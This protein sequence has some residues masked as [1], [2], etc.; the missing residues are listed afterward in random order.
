MTEAKLNS[1]DMSDNYFDW[2]SDT[3]HVKD[4][5]T[6]PGRGA[7]ILTR[8]DLLSTESIS[9]VRKVNETISSIAQI[10][11]SRIIETLL[12]ATKLT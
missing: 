6:S 11:D 10:G 2:D 7:A 4:R 5:E 9:D 3:V 12:R 8:R 1:Q